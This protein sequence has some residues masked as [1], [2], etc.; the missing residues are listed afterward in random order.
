MIGFDFYLSQS[1]HL[2]PPERERGRKWHKYPSQQVPSLFGSTVREIDLVMID[3]QIIIRRTF[4]GKKYTYSAFV[5]VYVTVRT[6]KESF[7]SSCGMVLTFIDRSLH[8]Q[9]P[10]LL[11]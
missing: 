4:D 1:L 2:E 6:P 7:G 10:S 11:R 3:G 8:V 9:P 5:H